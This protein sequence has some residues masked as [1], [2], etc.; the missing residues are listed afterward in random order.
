M[1]TKRAEK[2][3]PKKILLKSSSQVP[4]TLND[5]RLRIVGI[6]LLTLIIMLVFIRETQID[7][8]LQ[9][10]VTGLAYV[11]ILWHVIRYV[12][13]RNRK[14]FPFYEEN[15]RR[16]FFTWITVAASSLF[17]FTTG[18][19]II[20]AYANGGNVFPEGNLQ[21]LL[22]DNIL[23]QIISFIILALYE[24]LYLFENWKQGLILGEDLKRKKIEHDLDALKTQV[25]PHFL[26]NSLSSLA[27]LIEEDKT[28]AV[29][30][31]EE[32]S[33]V[34]RYMLQSNE[35]TLIS[36]WKEIEFLEAYFSLLKIRFGKGLNEQLSISKEF[37][38]YRIPPLTLQSLVDN[39]IQHNVLSATKPLQINISTSFNNS[40]IV[41]NNLQKKTSVLRSEYRVGL[42]D[43]EAK[44][45]SLHQQLPTVKENSHHFRVTIPLIK[46]SM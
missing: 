46:A 34:Y 13:I 32:L 38:E 4:V 6:P 26:F 7:N 17:C 25:N 45:R 28:R 12:V 22:L 15:S 14:N 43:L 42:A 8:I 36:L 41:E 19:L 33:H 24:T 18:H 20:T 2:Y 29:V 40:I 1:V 44:F 10:F 30:F 27:S 3:D 31:V 5:R 11:F 39:A 23:G 37:F 9:G 21:G 16:L 35:I